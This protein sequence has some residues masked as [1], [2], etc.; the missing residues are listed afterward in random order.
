VLSLGEKIREMHASAEKYADAAKQLEV[1]AKHQTTKQT[2]APRPEAGF[3]LQ[4]R[5]GCA[6]SCRRIPFGRRC[7]DNCA[8]SLPIDRS[9]DLVCATTAHSAI[10]LLFA[11]QLRT[12]Q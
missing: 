4:P 6:L 12:A 3:T 1:G 7:R 8:H 2:A 11:L 9:I 10:I 5:G